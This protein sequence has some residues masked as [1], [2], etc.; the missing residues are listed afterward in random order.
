MK[1][2]NIDI[3]DI[4]ALIED[5]IHLSI[6]DQKKIRSKVFYKRFFGDIERNKPKEE[7]KEEI[8]KRLKILSKIIK[9]NDEQLKELIEKAKINGIDL[10]NDK[11][12]ELESIEINIKFNNIN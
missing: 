7:A 11:E 8:N 2:L 3:K 6:T 5:Y 10:T 12:S 4:T 1:N 9:L